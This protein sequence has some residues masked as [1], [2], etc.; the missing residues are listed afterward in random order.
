M[1]VTKAWLF[2]SFGTKRIIKCNKSVSRILNTIASPVLACKKH[3][4][5]QWAGWSLSPSLF[6]NVLPESW[7]HI[8]QRCLEL[9]TM[10]AAGFHLTEHGCVA[11]SCHITNVWLIVQSW[12]RV[13]PSTPP[14]YPNS[15]GRQWGC[16]LFYSPGRIKLPLALSLPFM[17]KGRAVNIVQNQ[18]PLSMVS[19]IRA[20][21]LSV[22]L[23][24]P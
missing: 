4:D 13:R 2:F 6:L 3:I 8:L 15:W 20:M 12:K 21:D 16:L 24:L 7:C 22:C 23:S 1:R 9:W 14:C 19:L 10:P 17:N 11:H 5:T 18:L